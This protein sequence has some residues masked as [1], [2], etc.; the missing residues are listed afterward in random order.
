MSP[1][2]PTIL[3]VL[4][5]K[6]VLVPTTDQALEYTHTHTPPTLIFGLLFG[7]HTRQQG[8]VELR[9]HFPKEA[10]QSREY[11][12]GDDKWS[13]FNKPKSVFPN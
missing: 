1:Q 10:Q 13:S 9:D 2:V 12:Y 3:I 11:Q 8:L 6:H 4:V 7:V 5:C